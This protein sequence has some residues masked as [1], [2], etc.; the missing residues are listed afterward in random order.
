MGVVWGLNFLSVWESDCARIRLEYF[1]AVDK[2]LLR[3]VQQGF[4]PCIVGAWGYFMPCMGEENLKAYWRYLIARYGAWPAVWCAAGN[5]NLPWYRAE[6]FPSD[7]WAA[8]QRWCEIMWYTTEMHDATYDPLSTPTR[9]GM[10]CMIPRWSISTFC[11][12]RMEAPTWP[13]SAP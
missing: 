5:A 9:P 1:D 4:T 13:R 12:H 11:R 3:L 2:R 10:S 8:G 6:K 7:D